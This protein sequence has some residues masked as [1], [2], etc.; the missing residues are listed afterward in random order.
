MYISSLLSIPLVAGVLTAC[1][2]S[3]GSRPVQTDSAGSSTAAAGALTADQRRAM[4]DSANAFVKRATQLVLHPDSASTIALY[5]SSGP[6]V[7]V[8]MGQLTTSLDE[9]AK[10]IGTNARETPPD[11]LTINST[12]V[13]VLA[14]DA[15]AVTITFSGAGTDPK[16]HKRTPAKGAYTAVLVLREG[17]MRAIQQHQSFQVP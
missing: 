17:R 8:N 11:E 15:A 4:E 7:F 3:R 10:M 5:P 2:P 1:T 13:D 14:P 12:K 16:T 9:Q 6:I